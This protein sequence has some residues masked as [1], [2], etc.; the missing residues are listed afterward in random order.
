MAGLPFPAGSFDLVFCWGVLMHI[1]EA[2]AAM[3]ELVRLSRAG[4][5]IVIAE[6]NAYSVDAITTLLR[7]KLLPPPGRDLSRGR[8]GREY[9]TRT[10]AG[11]LFIR[12]AFP[13]AL[14]GFFEAQRCRLRYRMAGQFTETFTRAP[15][16]VAAF[17]H[18]WNA[19]W[20]RVGAPPWLACANIFV[21]EREE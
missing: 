18:A 11:D 20:F 9:W 1:P 15:A 5:L 10:P 7:S 14:R 13:S 8:Y 12:H 6:G 19:L 16:P 2:E 3:L 21:F 4:G 17:L